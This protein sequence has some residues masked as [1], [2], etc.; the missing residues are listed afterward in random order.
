MVNVGEEV[1]A[2]V[3]GC[4]WQPAG[5]VGGLRESGQGLTGA[6]SVDPKTL[7]GR[8]MAVVCKLHDAPLHAVVKGCDEKNELAKVFDIPDFICV[9]EDARCLLES[10]YATSGLF[11]DMIDRIHGC[12]VPVIVHACGSFGSKFWVMRRHIRSGKIPART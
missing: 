3:D 1:K 10:S 4:V 8:S 5:S 11:E 7:A 6:G 12:L 9:L 2:F